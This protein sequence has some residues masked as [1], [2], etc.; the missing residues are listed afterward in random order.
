MT[1]INK[2]DLL[3]P[4]RRLIPELEVQSS[5]RRR[6]DYVVMVV[7]LGL[8]GAVAVLAYLLVRSQEN[9]AFEAQFRIDSAD[10]VRAVHQEMRRNLELLQSVVSFYMASQEVDRREFERFVATSV[11]AHPG[12]Q[13]LQWA[14]LVASEDRDGFER[15]ARD[16]RTPRFEIT[17]LNSDGHIVRAM[18]RPLYCPVTYTVPFDGNERASGYDLLSHPERRQALWAARDSA[19]IRAST[20]LALVQGEKGLLAAAPV[21]RTNPVAVSLQM[22]QD[23]LS[24]FC[25]GVFRVRTIVERSLD[26]FQR[27]GISLALFDVT[28]PARPDLLAFHPADAPAQDPPMAAATALQG[29]QHVDEVPVAGRRWRILCT[30]SP[31][32]RAGFS[33]WQSWSALGGGAG[34][35]AFLAFSFLQHRRYSDSLEGRVARRTQQLAKAYQ[36]IEGEINVRNEAEK[37]LRRNREQLLGIIN[38]TTAVI[39]MKDPQ[40][41]YLLINER[42]KALFSL[43]EAQIIGRTDHDIFPLA[44]ADAIRANDLKVLTAVEALEIEEVVRRRD[45]PRTYISVKFALRDERGTAYAVCGISTDITERKRTEEALLASQQRYDLIL[46]GIRDGIWDWNLQS[47]E[48]YFSPHWKS[49]LGYAEHEV[50]NTFSAWQNLLHPDDAERATLTINAFLA[51]RRPVFEL[52][53]RLRHKDGTYRWI[54]ARGVALRDARGQAVRMAGSHVDLTERKRAEEELRLTN[55]AL[56]E[57]QALLARA[58]A[59]LKITNEQL[60]STQLQ[61][62][63]AEKLE[64]IGK[65][66]AGVAHEVKNPLQTMLMGL[67][68]LET[69][70]SAADQDVKLTCA[71]MRE[72]INRADAIVRGLLQ[73]AGSPE[74]DM[75]EEDL[76]VVLEKALWLVNYSMNATQVTAVRRLDSGLPRVWIDHGKMEQ[77]FI[78]LLTNAIQAMPHGGTLYVSTFAEPATDT[79]SLHADGRAERIIVQIQDTGTGIAP[80]NLERLFTPFFTT[81]QKGLGTGLGLSVTKSIVELHGGQIELRN[82]P[83]GGVRV[84]VALPATKE[85]VYEKSTHP[86]CR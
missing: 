46:N 83:G 73:M 81:K 52:E 37:A 60:Q 20:R 33:R 17:E 27:P 48:V 9:R 63:Q 65:L 3:N 16:V 10:R 29:L 72:A 74:L 6:R 45:E 21:Y 86:V 23:N 2:T 13:A 14:P 59:D 49:M 47:N 22:R 39:Y 19:E 41:R 55:V 34:L 28:D 80:E 7:S 12:V 40:G 84:T 5:S 31:V 69:K 79:G 70:L 67:T 44:V 11:A 82:A 25:V 53:H 85:H 57:R 62:I 64:S 4:H 76:N 32:Y 8:A 68:Y 56:E 38:N 36:D 78:N 1:T 71:D 66:A 51:G 61:L 15:S 30:P 42:Y 18:P 75:T 54:L 43:T 26:S 58:L 24:G 50:S 35:T 77:V